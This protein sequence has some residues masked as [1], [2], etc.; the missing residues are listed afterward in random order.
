MDIIDCNIGRVSVLDLITAGAPNN[1]SYQRPKYMDNT[2]LSNQSKLMKAPLLGGLHN[3][4][5]S[6]SFSHL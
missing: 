1:V 2:A 3:I 6:L 4:Q 5:Q